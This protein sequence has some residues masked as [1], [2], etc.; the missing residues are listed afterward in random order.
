MVKRPLGSHSHA[1]TD[2]L[3]VAH[4]F[5]VVLG[6]I[7]HMYYRHPHHDH[8]QYCRCWKLH[9]S[10]G[11]SSRNTNRRHLLV[12]VMM[13]ETCLTMHVV[14]RNAT[15]ESRSRDGGCHNMHDVRN[16][17]RSNHFHRPTCSVVI[18]IV[19]AESICVCVCVFMYLCVSRFRRILMSIESIGRTSHVEH[20]WTTIQ[21]HLNTPKCD[22]K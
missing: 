10:G 13:F 9:A 15:T 18:S 6:S 2:V 5:S 7:A 20:I 12:M 1:G 22:R 16:T 4:P 11:V 3:P 17:Q 21:C 8:H 14:D 19:V